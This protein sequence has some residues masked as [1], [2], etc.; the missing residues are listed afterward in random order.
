MPKATTTTSS[1][2]RF[3]FPSD[4]K[5]LQLVL[6]L[7]PYAAS[8]GS[9]AM[10][11]DRICAHLIQFEL[12]HDQYQGCTKA[13]HL[14]SRACRDRYKLLLEDKDRYG[15]FCCT[16]EQT[17]VK[18]LLDSIRLEMVKYSG[19]PH[20]CVQASQGGGTTD[21]E[22][23]PSSQVHQ[24]MQ[25][26]GETTTGSSHNSHSPSHSILNEVNR[27]SLIDHNHPSTID[28]KSQ[29]E[30]RPSAEQLSVNHLVDQK[31]SV[32]YILNNCTNLS[33][34]ATIQAALAQIEELRVMLKELIELKKNRIM[35]NSPEC[36]Q[37]SSSGDDSG[38]EKS[39]S[40][41][42]SNESTSSSVSCREDQHLVHVADRVNLL[43]D[44]CLKYQTQPSQSPQQL[45][46]QQDEEA[47]AEAVQQEQARHQ[48]SLKL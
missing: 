26:D 39:D 23:R 25:L 35:Q 11:W 47:A 20:V 7:K 45:Q 8:H 24:H 21:S 33:P 22:G 30:P 48:S 1:R 31:N 5:L 40:T 9:K 34:E 10:K 3:R 42:G 27:T 19:T 46:C 16:P 15:K 12:S 37:S 36:H 18:T 6:D 4:R 44:F 17:Q 13:K 41:S 14:T 32:D 28:C 43:Y 2:Y 38:S 29:E